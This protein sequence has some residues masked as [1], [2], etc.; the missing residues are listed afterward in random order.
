MK[1]ILH[2]CMPLFLLSN[3]GFVCC[4]LS[5]IEFNLMVRCC[6][7]FKCSFIISVVSFGFCVFGIAKFWDGRIWISLCHFGYKAQLVCSVILNYI[8]MTKCKR[9]LGIII[10]T[11]FLKDSMSFTSY[12]P[13]MEYHLRIRYLVF[14]FFCTFSLVSS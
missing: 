1:S 11:E 5:G 3:C 10:E 4:D 14:F 9:K 13:R 2:A 7:H 8:T 6:L 12:L